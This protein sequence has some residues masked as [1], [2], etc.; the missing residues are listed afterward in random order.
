MAAILQ[1]AQHHDA[2]EVSNVKRIGCWVNAYIGRYKFLSKK[3]FRARHHLVN[4]A[5]PFEFVYE[6]HRLFYLFIILLAKIGLFLG[7]G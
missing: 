7:I 3:F 1:V 5:T 6:I 4:H 2:T